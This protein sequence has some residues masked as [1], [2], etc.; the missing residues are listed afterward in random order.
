MRVCAVLASLPRVNTVPTRKY[1]TRGY[2]VDAAKDSIMMHF[3]LGFHDSQLAM[4]T[5]DPKLS[6]RGGWRA[7]RVPLVDLSAYLEDRGVQR[8][9]VLKIDCEGCEWSLLPSLR[10]WLTPPVS[11]PG[12][13]LRFWAWPSWWRPYTPRVERLV[14]E[15]HTGPLEPSYDFEMRRNTLGWMDAN[16]LNYEGAFALWPLLA[17]LFDRHGLA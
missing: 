3:P 6:S 1:L 15:L 8:V 5:N 14:G 10:S 13:K 9:R 2:R 7:Q 12:M 17:R 11:T 16:H 4:A